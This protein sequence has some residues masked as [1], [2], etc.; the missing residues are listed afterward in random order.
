MI[1]MLAGSKP[2]NKD[3]YFNASEVDLLEMESMEHLL[4][5]RINYQI[6]RRIV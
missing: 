2:S 5:N 1:N 3:T 4:I 6:I